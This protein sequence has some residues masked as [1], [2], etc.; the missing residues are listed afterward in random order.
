VV[1]AA[2]SQDGHALRFATAELRSDFLVLP[3]TFRLLSPRTRTRT[4][5]FPYDTEANAAG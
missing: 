2:V 5:T 3:F 4:N 1:L